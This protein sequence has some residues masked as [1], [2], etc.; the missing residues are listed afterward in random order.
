[1]TS[2]SVCMASYNG[3]PFIEKQILSILEN[4]GQDDELIIV[5]DC[6]NDKTIE[7]IE[8]FNDSRI[9]LNVNA[10]NSGEVYSFSKAIELSNNEVIFLCDQD[11]IWIKGRVDIMKSYL[12][13][14][15]A[16]LLTSN[17]SWIDDQDRRIQ[18]DFDGVCSDT[19]EKYYRN[20]LDIFIGK[21]N[22]FGCAMAF[23]RNLIPVI[24]PIP[25]YVESHDLWIEKS[26]NI[27]KSNLHINEETFYKRKHGYNVTSTTSNRP[28]LQKLNSRVIFLV[29]IIAIYKRLILR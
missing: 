10:K 8:N 18:I 9:K 23:K 26:A 16:I 15:D 25:S 4:L 6:S 2:V 27:I 22:Y 13:N 24:C 20:I 11:D 28:I 17:F 29:S 7:I 14:S 5:D 1:M 19:S 3:E 21:T 12:M